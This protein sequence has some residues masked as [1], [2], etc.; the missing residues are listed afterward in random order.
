M[1]DLFP[2]LSFGKYPTGALNSLT[3]V[4]G[5]LV[6]TKSVRLPKTND[7]DVVNTGVT[8]ILPRRDW[9]K[10][11]CFAAYHRFNGSGEMTGSHWI[12]ET[13]LLNS[14]IIITNSFGVGNCYNGV[15]EFA[16]KHYVDKETKLCDWFLT[17][18]VA[19]TFDGWLSDIGAMAV[20]ASD[21]V[22]GMEG[23]SSDAVPEGNTGGGTGMTTMGHKAGTGCASRVIDS[24]KVDAQGKQHATKYTLAVLVQ[25]NF[26]GARFL[27]VKGVPVGQIL[28]D[29]AERAKSEAPKDT[30]EG[31]IIVIVATDA[32]LIP[33]QL[34]RIAQRATVGISR[35][36]GWGSNYSGDLFLAFSTAHEI[37]RENTQNWTPSVPAPIEVLDTES[38]NSLFEATAEATE[39]AIYN[40]LCMAEDTIGPEDR[41]V[42]A[43]D[44]EKLTRIVNKHAYAGLD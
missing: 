29:E 27:T 39:E 7:H 43:L 9:F 24:I 6:S 22:E 23:A 42:K 28:M 26:G 32:P 4:P 33:I 5:V 19:E 13:G 20:Q 2:N 21:V 38:I 44:L 17:P 10:Q 8:C 11:G 1:R 15:Y 16:K 30:P 25:S 31:S 37:P 18:V 12:D 36:G 35:T 34:K 41:E 14:P 40:A 3:D